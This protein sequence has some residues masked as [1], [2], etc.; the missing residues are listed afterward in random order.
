MARG[1]ERVDSLGLESDPCNKIQRRNAIKP[2][3]TVITRTR[4]RDV[5]IIYGGSS[6]GSRVHVRTGS[7]GREFEGER[8]SSET[9]LQARERLGLAHRRRRA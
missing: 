6:E 4:V 2:E 3:F 1:M 7:R 9:F 8:K 5:Q